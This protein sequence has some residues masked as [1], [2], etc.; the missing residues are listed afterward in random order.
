MPRRSGVRIHFPLSLLFLPCCASS[1]GFRGEGR[2]HF[3]LTGFTLFSNTPCE[4]KARNDR[5]DRRL[6]L[7]PSAI[8]FCRSSKGF[9]SI[10]SGFRK[11][12]SER[13]E[14]FF[15][16]R[17]SASRILWRAHAIQGRCEPGRRAVLEENKEPSDRSYST[18]N[19][20]FSQAN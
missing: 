17:F 3:L 11:N 15:P 10:P 2:C 14:D 19:D 1:C 12:G 6:T 18:L 4:W 8:A 20:V 5:S 16:P 7:W 9:C 13:G